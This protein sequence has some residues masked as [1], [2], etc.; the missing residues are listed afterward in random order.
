[1]HCPKCGKI[2]RRKTTMDYG[3]GMIDARSAE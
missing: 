3:K 2:E 1:M